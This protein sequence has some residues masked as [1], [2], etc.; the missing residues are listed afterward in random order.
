VT[1]TTRRLS[2]GGRLWLAA[3][4]LLALAPCLDATGDPDLWWHLRVGRWIVEH[5]GVPHTELFSYTAPGAPWVAHE[6]LA[7][8]LFW[9]VSSGIGLAGLAVVVGLATWGGLLALARLGLKA[10]AT[11][12]NA[13]LVLVVGA[14]AMQ[15]VT[16]TRPQMFTF[17][18]VCV[19][20]L[21]MFT[22]L[23]RGGRAIWW[24][25][26]VIVVWANLHAGVVIGIAL[27]AMAGFAGFLDALW[28]HRLDR[29]QR[30]RLATAAAALLAGAAGGL[31]N[32]NGFDLYG[33]ALT[34]SSP[35]SH[36]LI[37][38]WQPTNFATLE[39]VPLVL[40]IVATLV[41]MIASRSRLRPSHLLFTALGVAAAVAAVRNISL[42]VA[43]V[44]PVLA[45]LL[46][47][48]YRLPERP[49][50][51]PAAAALAAAAVVAVSVAELG[52]TTSAASLA[53]TAPVC[54]VGELV[55]SGQ[56]VRLW[57]PYGEA[58]Y[59]I[60]QGWPRLRV[61]AYGEDTTLG[62]TVI[63]QYVR[64]AAG[65]TAEP[66]ATSL[67][68][69]TETTAVITAP[70]ALASELHAAGW[71]AVDTANNESLLVAPGVRGVLRASCP[72]T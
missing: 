39:S 59:A 4:G 35:A 45:E 40:L 62:A 11:P 49:L 25:V 56:Q 30:R 14:K 47:L 43:L 48:R 64:I 21:L 61:Y 1:Q 57:L 13:G 16:G 28:Q 8:L 17:A 24:L 46:P 42:T 53:H 15:P 27:V 36:R 68:R 23:Q 60:D 72:G 71:T 50:L 34:G 32:P 22:H 12:F 33:R 31:L 9:V 18:L 20:L 70:G 3:A 10:G 7:E 2:P 58:G 19:C 52:R 6:W 55:A 65:D 41:S 38:E 63:D 69:A 5:G 37:Q 29:E 66:S 54:L 67:L 51:V 44:S 26:P